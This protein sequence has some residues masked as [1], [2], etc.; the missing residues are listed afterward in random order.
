MTLSLDLDFIRQQFPAT[1][2]NWAF[3]E[4]A[5]G[6]FVPNS[7]IKRMT[8]YMTECQVQPGELYPA[9]AKAQSRMDNGHFKMAELIGADPQETVIAASTS[10]N[11]YV[12]AQALRP[13]WQD[14]DNI[15][16]TNLNHEANSGP[17]RRLADTGINV[18]E[19]SINP[20]TGQLDLDLLQQLLTDRTRLVAFPHVSNITGE[21][22]DIKAITEMVH[23]AGA[24]VFVDGVAFAPHRALD[25][26]KWDVDYYVFSFYK[27]F[28]PHMGCLYGKHEKLLRAR[29]QYHYFIGEDTL[30][31][32]LNPSGPNHESIAS[33]E[34]IAD[35]FEA[36]SLHHLGP[37]YG[38]LRNG[39]AQMFERIQ[40]HEEK[41][42]RLFLDFCASKANLKL[43]GPTDVRRR[44]PTFS[45]TV[46]GMK[47]GDIPALVLDEKIGISSG[48]FYAKRLVEALGVKDVNDGVVRC[49]ALHYTTIDDMQRLVNALDQII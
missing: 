16:V 24:E 11:V 7:V 31:G 33:L 6:S 44:A 40:I 28:G 38:D 49:S 30:P 25:L 47:S 13:L 20:D 43:F 21:V 15:I 10:I 18:T 9:S 4:N 46:D 1:C 42:S 23:D 22:N 45:F 8:D 17:W 48:H 3:F 37:G 34:G 26:K 5:G 27:L 2:W 36:L 35:Y 41:L 32:K 19:W 29:N 39:A 14:G 12:M